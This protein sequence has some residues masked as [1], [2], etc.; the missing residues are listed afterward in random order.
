[1]FQLLNHWSYASCDKLC[2]RCD[3]YPHAVVPQMY[4]GQ[5]AILYRPYRRT[6]PY[7]YTGTHSIT[8]PSNIGSTLK[9]FAVSA[10]RVLQILLRYSLNSTCWIHAFD[11]QLYQ[12]RIYEDR[13]DRLRKKSAARPWSYL[14]SAI[15]LIWQNGRG[16]EATEAVF[17]PYTKKAFHGAVRTGLL[18]FII[19]FNCL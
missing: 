8:V 16:S 19:L 10:S 1:M 4:S 5:Q 13:Q 12:Q 2:C 3:A 14:L 15:E 17:C 11:P 6:L 18:Y 7:K 9:Y